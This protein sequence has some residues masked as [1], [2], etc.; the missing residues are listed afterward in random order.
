M[1]LAE[2]VVNKMINGDAFSN[3][4]GIKVMNVSKGY[5][6][7]KMRVRDEMTNGFG[8]AHGG[9][10]FSLADSALAFAA[11]SDGILGLGSLR[12]PERP[13]DASGGHR[14]P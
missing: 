13:R 4:L 3:W 2:K 6:K 10:A 11:I 12:R 5:C 14:R 7:L 1:E 8:I 9:I